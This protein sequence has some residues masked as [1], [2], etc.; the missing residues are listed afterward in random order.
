MPYHSKPK[1]ESVE[2]DGEKVEFKEGAMRKQMKMKASDKLTKSKLERIAKM[3]TGKKFKMF[4][5]E[6]IATPLLKRRANFALTLM[7]KKSK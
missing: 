3:E 5:K 2:L 7:K 1:M 4:D 6:H